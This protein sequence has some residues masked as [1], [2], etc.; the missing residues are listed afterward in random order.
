MCSTKPVSTSR[1]SA[2]RYCSATSAENSPTPGIGALAILLAP[3]DSE[4][5]PDVADGAHLVVDEAKREE[6]IA[7]R[8][9]GD[10]GRHLARLLR[11]RD[12]QTAVDVERLQQRGHLLLEVGAPRVERHDHGVG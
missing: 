1:R 12:P 7:H 8:V 10:V 4:A 9:L 2:K 5:G 3:D 11:P 6:H